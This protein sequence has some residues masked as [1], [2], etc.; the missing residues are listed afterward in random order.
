MLSYLRNKSLPQRVENISTYDSTSLICFS[1]KER[2]HKISNSSP[3]G[4]GKYYYFINISSAYIVSILPTDCKFGC[5]DT[6]SLF[7]FGKVRDNNFNVKCRFS[8]C[9]VCLAYNKI[10]C[11]ENTCTNILCSSH[12]AL[13]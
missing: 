3:G 8:V 13:S 7:S 11:F 10:Y 5:S 9:L 4:G 6:I 2:D 1:E 12:Y